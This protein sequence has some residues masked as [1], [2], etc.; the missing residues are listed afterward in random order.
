MPSTQFRLGARNLLVER[1][2]IMEVTMTVRE[3]ARQHRISLG[4][5]Y[6]RIWEKRVRAMKIDGRWSILPNDSTSDKVGPTEQD[7]AE[8]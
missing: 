1:R 6:L 2:Q 3:Y 8:E 5:A 4:S 7:K